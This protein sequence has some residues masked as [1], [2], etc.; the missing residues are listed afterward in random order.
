MNCNSHDRAINDTNLRFLL[1]LLTAV[2]NAVPLSSMGLAH[3]E[4]VLRRS[5][6]ALLLAATTPKCVYRHA[7]K[8]GSNVT[9]F[10][11]NRSKVVT[12]VSGCH[13]F[14]FAFLVPFFMKSFTFSMFYKKVLCL[15]VL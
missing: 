12:L 13:N 15:Y 3:V 2:F 11:D 5:L 8:I 4:A 7:H 10:C 1:L 14:Y 6:A 9:T